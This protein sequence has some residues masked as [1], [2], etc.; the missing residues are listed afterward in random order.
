MLCI[1]TRSLSHPFIFSGKHHCHTTGCPC[2]A[3]CSHHIPRKPFVRNSDSCLHAPVLAA[4]VPS[5][6]ST[7]LH[8]CHQTQRQGVT[9]VSHG[10]HRQTGSQQ[11]S[12]AGQLLARRPMKHTPASRQQPLLQESSN[13]CHAPALC[14]TAC[15]HNPS[16]AAS[17]Q[18]R[19]HMQ[20]S[21]G[22]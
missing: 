8:R 21:L 11:A 19:K 16:Q 1:T 17:Q 10:T 6:P 15:R 7:Q 20:N 14:W 18:P 12:K 3:T 13:C 4:S 2:T 22:I 9:I 5:M